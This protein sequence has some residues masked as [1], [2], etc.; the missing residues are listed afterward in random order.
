M[1]VNGVTL[2]YHQAGQ[3]RALLCV[4]GNFA[5]KRWFT[6]LLNNPPSGWQVIAFDL[7]NF[8]ASDAMPE[9][10]SIAA[11]A[12]Y[13]AGFIDALVLQD[14]V[15][16]GHSLG[17]AVVQAYAAEHPG[18]PTGLML[19]S[20]AA[21]SGLQTPEEHYPLLESFQDNREL[22]AQALRPTMPSGRPAYFEQIVDD[23][24]AMHPAAFTG[25]ARALEHH[26]VTNKLKPVPCPVLVVRGEHD[27]LITEEMAR[28]TANAFPHAQ[29]ELL[30]GVG[31]SPQIEAPQRFNALLHTF[32]EGLS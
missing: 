14:V 23:A 27:Y 22:L 26:H 3:G 13:L 30:D 12:E 17:G 32:L 10:I 2:A 1:N 11:Y 29:L 16:V 7:P 19:V 9:P 31:H 25:N 20:S 15:L 28:A 18:V 6:E 4:H 21:P 24:L 8:G 5:S